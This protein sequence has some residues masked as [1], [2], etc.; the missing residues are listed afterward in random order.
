VAHRYA[1]LWEPAPP[2]DAK[3]VGLAVQRDDHV[4]VEAPNDM[5]IPPRYDEPFVVAGPDLAPVTYRPEDQQYFDQVL[6]DLSRAFIIGEVEA[7]P[8][9]TQGVILRL[10]SEKVLR[11]MRAKR[12]AEYATV[13]ARYPAVQQYRTEYYGDPPA[14]TEQATDRPAPATSEGA[15]VAA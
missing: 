13:P 1:V 7:V 15:P 6:L 5:C 14:A 10:L 12:A 4:V 8:T 2:G 3:P 9:A 11:P